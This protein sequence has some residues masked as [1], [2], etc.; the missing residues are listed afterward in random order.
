MHAAG[1]SIGYQQADVFADRDGNRPPVALEQDI[2]KIAYG[3][4]S[5]PVLGKARNDFR[6]ADQLPEHGQGQGFVILSAV[7]GQHRHVADQAVTLAGEHVEKYPLGGCC[8]QDVDVGTVTIPLRHVEFT[9][10]ERAGSEGRCGQGTGP[11]TIATTGEVIAEYQRL[12]F[13]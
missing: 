2:F 7:L 13:Q 1:A 10:F 8:G 9:A 11:A 6:I 4:V 3:P 5:L 12:I